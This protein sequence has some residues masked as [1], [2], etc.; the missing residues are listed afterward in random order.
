MANMQKSDYIIL[1][2]MEYSFKNEGDEHINKGISLYCVPQDNLE[3]FED[4]YRSRNGMIARG[5]VPIKFSVPID[6]KSQ[7]GPVPGMYSVSYAL[8]YGGSTGVRQRVYGLEYIYPIGIIDA[9]SDVQGNG[10]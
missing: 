6:L 1:S 3:P 5:Y 10:K 2:A 4:I 9:Q 8:S 7:I